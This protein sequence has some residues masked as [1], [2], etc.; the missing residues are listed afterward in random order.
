MTE[1]SALRHGRALWRLYGRGMSTVQHLRGAA[2]ITLGGSVELEIAAGP[3]DA[4]HGS[5][6]TPQ[7]RFQIAS[8][9]K[10]FVAAAHVCWPIAASWTWMRPSISGFRAAR[11]RGGPSKYVIY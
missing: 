1:S 6:S 4:E 11:P 9:S 2:S 10:Q 8:V 5:L 7:T 3:A